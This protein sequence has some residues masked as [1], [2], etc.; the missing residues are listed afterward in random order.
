MPEHPPSRLVLI[1]LVVLLATGCTYQEVVFK[2]VNGA[3]VSRLDQRGV[4][5]NLDV[6]LENPN[7]F[8]IKV[9]DPDVDVYLNELYIGKARLDER[10]VLPPRSTGIYHIPLH[11]SFDG[12][13]SN[14]MGA[15]L[16][17]TL[18]GR[19]DLRVKGTVRAGT[20]LFRRKFPFEERHT[21]DL[22]R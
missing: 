15:L 11:A 21:I 14:A 12:D 8:R 5:L 17:A 9:Q 3:S 4:A 22:R 2:G 10:I 18:S 16:V 13:G 6:T 7:G 20:W 19:G 1:L